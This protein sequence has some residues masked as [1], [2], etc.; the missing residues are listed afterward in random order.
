MAETKQGLEVVVK[1]AAGSAVVNS[2]GYSAGTFIPGAA[3]AAEVVFTYKRNVD[4]SWNY[5]IRPIHNAGGIVTHYKDGIPSGS[6]TV[7]SLYIDEA[8]FAKLRE[9]VNDSDGS[10]DEGTVPWGYMEIQYLGVDGSVEF[11]LR[12]KRV[13]LSNR[14]VSNPEDDS[15]VNFEFILFECPVK[16]TTS[17]FS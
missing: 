10:V 1:F 17:L 8:D 3:I 7:S 16:T 14:S 6:L 12:C 13:V 2:A 4:F 5:N 11:I 15:S 9:V